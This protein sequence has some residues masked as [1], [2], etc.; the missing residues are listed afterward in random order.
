MNTSSTSVNMDTKTS[1]KTSTKSKI[2]QTSEKSLKSLEIPKVPVQPS[3][4]HHYPEVFPPHIPPEIKYNTPPIAE[5]I[6]S[7]PGKGIVITC[8]GAG[9][10]PGTYGCYGPNLIYNRLGEKLPA[11]ST[12]VGVIQIQ[13]RV[14]GNSSVAVQDTIETLNYVLAKYSLPIILVGWSMGAEVITKATAHFYRIAEASDNAVDIA[15]YERIR[16]L[17]Y[18]A[19]Q[20]AGVDG[21]KLFAPSSKK[22]LIIHGTRDTCLNVKCAISLLEI[23]SHL[24]PEVMLIPYAE[25]DVIGCDEV[26]ERF[27]LRTFNDE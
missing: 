21:L 6:P 23:A 13:Y 5:H 8:A 19:G 26:V 12:S 22:V 10:G 18:L 9:G 1:T 11:C 2:G 20:T 16:G 7:F 3:E 4:S 17:V 14:P 25:H 24:S 27:I 15:R